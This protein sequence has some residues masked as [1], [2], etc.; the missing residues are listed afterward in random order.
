MSIERSQA[1]INLVIYCGTQKFT[2]KHISLARSNYH[3]QFDIYRKLVFEN[4][5]N[6]GII[7]NSGDYLV[8][9]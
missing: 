6:A 2:D 9:E 4:L 8:N 5:A 1:E 3:F 7:R